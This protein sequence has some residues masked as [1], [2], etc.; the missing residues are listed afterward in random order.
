M[1]DINEILKSAMKNKQSEIV[2]ILRLVK[3][4]IETE[5]KKKNRKTISVSELFIQCV[6]KELS[7]RKE[8][9]G[10]ES[11][12][13]SYLQ[14]FLPKEKSKADQKKIV[15]EVIDM[16]VSPNLGSVMKE[17]KQQEGLDM[18]YCSGLVRE[19]L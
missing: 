5:L 6:R 8:S 2:S 16:L 3:G 13:I 10:D 17:L 7:E 14:A 9:K 18:K 1:S 12:A 11:F 19:L 4:K 15:K